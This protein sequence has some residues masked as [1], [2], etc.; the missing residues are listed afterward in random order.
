MAVNLHKSL[1]NM[2]SNAATP[3]KASRNGKNAFAKLASPGGSCRALLR[4]D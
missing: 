1:A 2:L 3:A 4:H